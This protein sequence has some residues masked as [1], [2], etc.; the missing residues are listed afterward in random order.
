MV[1]QLRERRQRVELTQQA[2]A[3]L[4]SCSRSMVRLLEGGYEPP[5]RSAV[6][7]RIERVLDELEASKQR[8]AA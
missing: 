1:N 3:D 2:L 8:R 6:R 7:R 4:A 5:R